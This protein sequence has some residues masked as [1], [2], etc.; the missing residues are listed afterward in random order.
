MQKYKTDLKICQNSDL[1]E[2]LNILLPHTKRAYFVGGCVRDSLLGIE[3]VDFDIEIYD[4]SPK[5][6][7]NL[8]QKHGALGVGKSFFVYKW[9]NFDLALARVESKNG[10]GHKAFSVNVCDDE[11][12]A[13]SRRDFS[14]NAI[15][16]NI[17]NGEL[18]DF[19]D[20]INDLKHKIL[21]I[22]DEKSFKDD[23]LRVLRAIQFASRFNLNLDA[24]SI[25]IMRQIDISDLSSERI[26]MELYKFF[27]AKNYIKGVKALKELNLD[28]KIFGVKI[29]LNFAKTANAHHK[30]T[31]NPLCFLYDLSV[32]FPNLNIIKGCESVLKQPVL[33]S[34]STKNLLKLAL[35][36]PL[37][38]WLG[39]NTSALINKAKKLKIYD[40]KLSININS[41][42]FKNLSP[43][44][45]SLAIENAQKIAINARANAHKKAL[46][47]GIDLGSNTLRACIINQD[48]KI[49]FSF[50]RIVGSAK[51]LSQNGLADDAKARIK[52]ALG[53]FKAELKSWLDDF[54]KNT[55]EHLS[56]SLASNACKNFNKISNTI[57]PIYYYGAATQA[58]RISKNAKDFFKEI[59]NELKISFNIINASTEAALTRQG[60]TNRACIL[61]INF[62]NALFIDLGGA[63]TE[64]SNNA[65]F[66][67]FDFGIVTFSQNALFD[68]DL[69][70]AFSS[71]NPQNKELLKA[72]NLA[73]N[74][75]SEAKNYAN[76]FDL[77]C[78]ILTSGVPTSA[79]AVLKRISYA[80]YDAR[81]INGIKLSLTDLE[82]SAQI[83]ASARSPELLVGKDRANL[84]LGG[85]LLLSELLANLNVPFIVIDDGLREGISLALKNRNLAR[86]T[87]K[88]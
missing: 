62:K 74:C 72:K 9:R 44:Q 48:E 15:M 34:K 73:K 83:I 23:S 50:E 35:K 22:V 76:S 12:K 8:M 18:L 86:K 37:K 68:I 78:V 2:L 28:E 5:D 85:I 47:L 55:S 17:F 39:L 58:F 33:K 6:F 59:K 25:Q 70:K 79:A 24:K 40:K 49:L 63:S 66:K 87:L 36:M 7:E 30:I 56:Q 4:I 51:N 14:I 26:R 19:Y 65:H 20:G 41:A 75:V 52:E 3:C 81:L 21:K 42:N 57:M 43:K 11:R 61:G 64:I 77:E 27:N 84:V 29:P 32:K 53:E 82:K 88:F 46:F 38:N 60:I 16:V 71:K 10:L 67:S 69:F 1:G 13:S 31:Q 45:K 80:N 54:F